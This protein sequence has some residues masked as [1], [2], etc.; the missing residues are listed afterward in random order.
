MAEKVSIETLHQRITLRGEFEKFIDVAVV[1][2]KESMDKHMIIGNDR[3]Y[4]SF[5]KALFYTGNNVLKASL[6]FYQYGRFV[7]MGVGK[8]MPIGGRQKTGDE[9]FFKKRN[10]FGQLHQLT[11]KPKLWY[12]KTKTR[13]TK[14]L[15]E[16]FTKYYQVEFAKVMEL[17]SVPESIK[18]NL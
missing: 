8:G 11:R 9:S 18:I 10:E 5:K 16:V 13:Q 17:T 12:S 1:A 2:F 4:N 3:L 7:D 14:R 15:R 6:S